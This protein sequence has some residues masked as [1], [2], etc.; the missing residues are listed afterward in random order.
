MSDAET[1][2]DGRRRQQLL[3][4]AEDFKKKGIECYSQ[5]AEALDNE[6]V[7]MRL[8]QI[9]PEKRDYAVKRAVDTCLKQAY[10]KIVSKTPELDGARAL[11]RTALRLA[12]EYV[13]KTYDI[14]SAGKQKSYAATPA[15]I[16]RLLILESLTSR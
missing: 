2:M 4:D 1:E 9:C 10:P 3:A 8:A 6:G 14:A 12:P 15:N 11:V 7:Y 16:K 5:F 13:K